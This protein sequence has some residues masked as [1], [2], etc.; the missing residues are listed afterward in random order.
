MLRFCREAVLKPVLVD[1]CAKLRL[2][3]TEGVARAES[4]EQ[5]LDVELFGQCGEWRL[6]V[7]VR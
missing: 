3:A 1:C 5:G 4:V 7:I 2:G 6:E